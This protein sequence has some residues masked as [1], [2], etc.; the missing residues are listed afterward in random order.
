MKLLTKEILKRFEKTGRQGENPIVIAKFF[1]P[2]GRGNWY[3]TE[4]H[5]E[6][7]MFFGFVRL[8]Y[9]YNDEWGDFSLDELEHLRCPPLGLPIERDLHFTPKPFD[10]IGFTPALFRKGG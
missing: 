3:A 2:C 7:R 4:Y 6:E 9:D 8:F 10:E 1:N 5:P